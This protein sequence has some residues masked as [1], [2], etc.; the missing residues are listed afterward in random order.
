MGF[1]IFIYSFTPVI[2][3]L[4]I[5]FNIIILDINRSTDVE[6]AKI[7]AKR[8]FETYDV[9]NKKHLNETNVGS[10]IGII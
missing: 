10:M 7:V 2:K 4:F 1:Y 5:Y 3:D 6:L 9:E 8:L